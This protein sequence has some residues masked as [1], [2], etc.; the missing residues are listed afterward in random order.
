MGTGALMARISSSRMALSCISCRLLS[1]LFCGVAVFCEG[2]LLRRLCAGLGVA[3]SAIAACDAWAEPRLYEMAGLCMLARRRCG[4]RS[5]VRAPG[6]AVMS[7]LLPRERCKLR[8]SAS[9]TVRP[10]SC[11]SSFKT[12]S[13]DLL[14]LR[15][16]S[17][18]CGGLSNDWSSKRRGVAFRGKLG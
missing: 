8:F 11:L 4:L 18:R 9:S 2:C 1:L 14:R 12:F 10:P 17:R 13:D 15:L 16:L 6:R 5:I 7:S 3:L